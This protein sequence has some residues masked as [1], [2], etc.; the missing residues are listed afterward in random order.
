MKSRRNI[1]RVH[2]ID[3]SGGLARGWWV[4]LM[5]NGKVRA[6]RFFSDAQYDSTHADL[7]EAEK[8]LRRR[9]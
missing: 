5:R 9:R 2:P 6:N 1:A 8:F 7:T 4:R 3:G